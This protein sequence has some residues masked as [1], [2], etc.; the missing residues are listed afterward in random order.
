MDNNNTLCIE[1][2]MQEIRREIRE[3]NLSS[4]MLSFDDVPYKKADEVNS[5]NS[6]AENNTALSLSYI[7][8]HCNIQP[9]KEL[10]GNAVKVFFKKVIRKLTKFYVEPIVFE[11]NGF[12]SHT[13]RILNELKGQQNDNNEKALQDALN[14]LEILELKNKALSSRIEKLEAENEA[15]TMTD[16]SGK[17]ETT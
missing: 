12:N 5:T 9:Y 4:D 13:V 15:L 8:S 10:E 11:Q 6:D 2:I 16:N 3:K 1:T 14:R 17:Q 7:N